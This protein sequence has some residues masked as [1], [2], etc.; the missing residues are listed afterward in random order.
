[1]RN[2]HNRIHFVI[3]EV[4]PDLGPILTRSKILI[5][6]QIP[7]NIFLL[8]NCSMKI[9]VSQAQSNWF[10]FKKTVNFKKGCTNLQYE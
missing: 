2:Y 9:K 7:L 6:R 1:M 5:Y 3:T 8:T 4:F 10:V